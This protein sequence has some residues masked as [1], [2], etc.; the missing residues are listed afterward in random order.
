MSTYF[1]TREHRPVKRKIVRRRL[2]ANTTDAANDANRV[3]LKAGSSLRRVYIHNRTGTA[4]TGGIRIGNAAGGAQALAATPVAANALVDVPVV[5]PL[6]S[7]TD[8]TLFIE[9]VTAWGAGAAVDVVIEYQQV[10]F[11]ETE[12]QP[13]SLNVDP[14]LV[15]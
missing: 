12:Y 15:R 6:L 7:K 5:A 14:T 8:Q 10:P 2:A 4:V 1:F 13:G 11:V 3:V 9:D